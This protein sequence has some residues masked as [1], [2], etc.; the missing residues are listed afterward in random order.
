MFSGFILLVLLCSYNFN[1][2]SS[3]C[4]EDTEF[5][6]TVF[7]SPVKSNASTT[8]FRSGVFF[9]KVLEATE[10]LAFP[11]DRVSFSYLRIVIKK[12]DPVLALVVSCNR[13]GA[14]DI[15]VDK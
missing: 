5:I 13:K 12:Y 9:Y 1:I 14:S 15:S 8:A 7:S 10:E 11:S 2:N 4:A 6:Q 3:I